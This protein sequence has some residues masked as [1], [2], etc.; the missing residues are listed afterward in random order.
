MLNGLQ[1]F[2]L[3][4]QKEPI[5]IKYAITGI[6]RKNE[7]FL[8]IGFWIYAKGLKSAIDLAQNQWKENASSKLEIIQI[9]KCCNN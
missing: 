4:K 5:L 2:Y 8:T 3:E 1:M 9:K 7:K 6:A